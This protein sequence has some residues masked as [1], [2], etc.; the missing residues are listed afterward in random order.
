MIE[1]E[2]LYDQLRAMG[3]AWADA[4]S[5][6]RLLDDTTKTVLAECEIEAKADTENTTQAALERAGRVANKYREHLRALGE[7]R[8]VANRA[9]VNFDALQAYIELMRSKAAY[10]R[11]EMTLR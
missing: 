1:P 4:D 11:A 8:R 2:V 5:A 3:E 9:R 6:Y 7:A 10:E